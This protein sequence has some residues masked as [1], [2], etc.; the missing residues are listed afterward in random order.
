MNHGMPLARMLHVTA[1]WRGI[2]FERSAR[3]LLALLSAW[4]VGA[5]LYVSARRIFY[6]YDLEWMEGGVYEH[7]AR[8]LAG[9]PVYVVPSLDFTPYVYTPLY[10][11]VSAP[12][13]AL[14]GPGLPALRLVSLL[15]T[16]G[17]FVVLFELVRHGTR[18]RLCAWFGVGMFAACFELGGSWFDLARVDM[19]ALCLVLLAALLLVRSERFDAVAGLLFALAFLT[20]QSSLIAALPLLAVRVL[21][22]RGGRRVH[23]LLTCVAL[24]GLSTFVLDRASSGWYRFYVFELPGSHPIAKQAWRGYWTFDVFKDLPFAAAGMLYLLLQPQP[25]RRALTRLALCAGLLGS[26]W[27]GRLHTGGHTNVLLPGLLV[28]SWALAEALHAWTAA[29]GEAAQPAPSSNGRPR[30]LARFAYVVCALQLAWLWYSP[31]QQIPSARA[32]ATSDRLLAALRATPGPVL[33]P[34][35]GHLARLAGKPPH[36]HEMAFR[37][38]QLGKSMLAKHALHVSITS[39][40]AE[41]RYPVIVLDDRWWELELM[42]RYQRSVD[43]NWLKPELLRPVAGLEVSPRDVFVPLPPVRTAAALER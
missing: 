1:A 19:L 16:L 5:F 34:F 11:W 7:V 36:G 20:K 42:Q 26:S 28:L 41:Q 18:D 22:Q 24:I 37:D 12:F 21:T 27:S 4:Y 9:Q 35:H 43:W 13:L 39:A 33:V 14:L 32:R 29:D 31:K 10:Y 17:L 2:S 3:A 6:P 15:S 23:A 40:I 30:A 25:W 8:V 38:I